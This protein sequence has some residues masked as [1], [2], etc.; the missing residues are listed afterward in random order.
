MA[1]NKLF[2]AVL[3]GYVS[4][5]AQRQPTK[6][7]QPLLQRVS[8]EQLCL[9]HEHERGAEVYEAYKKQ[10]EA[11]ARL[12]YKDTAAVEALSSVAAKVALGNAID[13]AES[14]TALYRSPVT[15]PVFRDAYLANRERVEAVA[16]GDWKTA[17]LSGADRLALLAIQRALSIDL[18]SAFRTACSPSASGRFSEACREKGSLLSSISGSWKTVELTGSQETA[19]E[20]LRLAHL[21]DLAS[22]LRNYFA[23]PR[24]ASTPVDTAD[25]AVLDGVGA[26]SW[27]TDK[28][29][30]VEVNAVCRMGFAARSTR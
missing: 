4:L 27:R 12:T 1:F 11:G 13:L 16:G 10:I 3:L 5:S 7:I 14:L 30:R 15:V 23:T 20:Q 18:G 17:D 6:A 9:P 28:L 19:I 2:G 29:T 25:M 22:A 24:S 8:L 26:R 21:I